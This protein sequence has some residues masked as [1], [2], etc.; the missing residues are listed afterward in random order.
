MSG[1]SLCEITRIDPKTARIVDV[2]L[3]V[4]AAANGWWPRLLMADAPAISLFALLAVTLAL[5]RLSEQSTT[6]TADKMS[7]LAWVG[8]TL[9]IVTPSASLAWLALAWLALLRPWPT[10][11]RWLLLSLV[12]AELFATVGINAIKPWLL[13][14]EAALVATVMQASGMTVSLS[15]NLLSHGEHHLLVRG[16]CSGLPGALFTAL[17]VATLTLWLRPETS[18]RVLAMATIL[19]AVTAFSINVVRLMIMALSPSAYVL[20]HDDVGALAVDLCVG[21]LVCL[22]VMVV[23]A[24]PQAA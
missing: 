10:G 22:A 12:S 3:V 8:A 20:M 7:V 2:G 21:L 6:T 18:T 15:G 14:A 1:V 16:G 17:A 9:L 11:V 4:L 23:G 19:A 5:L 24:R 13:A